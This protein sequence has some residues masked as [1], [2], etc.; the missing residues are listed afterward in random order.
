ML[1]P[2]WE[3]IKK[4]IE[5]KVILSAAVTVDH[6]SSQVEYM[7]RCSLGTMETRAGQVVR[8]LETYLLKSV[9]FREVI[10][11]S[12]YGLPDNENLRTLEIIRLENG[13]ATVSFAEMAAKVRSSDVVFFVKKDFPKDL[14]DRLIIPNLVKQPKFKGDML[15][16]GLEVMLD[17][18]DVW[19]GIFKPFA[20]RNIMFNE[21]IELPPENFNA[22][23]PESFK[24]KVRRARRGMLAG[25]QDAYAFFRNASRGFLDFES[26][27]TSKRLRSM[28]SIDPELRFEIL[29]LVP[30]L[31]SVDIYG[32]NFPITLPRSVRIRMQSRIEGVEVF[33]HGTVHID[34]AVLKSIIKSIAAAIESKSA[35]L[36]F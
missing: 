22:L 32:T 34:L 15:E 13:I 7:F 2:A 18:A 26:S 20:V 29:D 33:V 5:H 36:K 35:A 8:I 21:E 10:D 16:V 17:Y 30:S 19:H 28:V 25:N 4:L 1:G 23:L 31:Q 24:E 9:V 12:G 11:A 27:E 3:T 6:S 14:R